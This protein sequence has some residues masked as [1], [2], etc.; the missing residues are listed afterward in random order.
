[1]PTAKKATTKK[2]APAKKKPAPKPKF[3]LEVEGYPNSG[4]LSFLS[5]KIRDVALARLNDHVG[6]VS[7]GMEYSIKDDAGNDF[8]Y[9]TIKSVSKK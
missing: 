9:M 6:L 5:E 4:T 1:M 3:L 2:K 7:K 8:R